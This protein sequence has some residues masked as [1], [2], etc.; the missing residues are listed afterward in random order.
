MLPGALVMLVMGPAS[1]MIGERYGSRIPLGLGALLAAGGLLLLGLAHGTQ[2]EVLVFTT[3]LFSGIGLAF[4]AMPNLIVDAVTPLE[5]GEATGFNALVRSIGSSLGSQVSAS[6]LAGSIVVA[7]GAPSN[8]SFR[9]AFFVG[10]G[11][12]VLAALMAMLI[13]RVSPGEHASHLGALESA[14][15]AGPL[16]EPALG[17][18]GGR[19]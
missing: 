5:T 7:G 15:A 8:A 6:I 12:A 14:G 9:T 13:P 1:G 3:V 19:A 10:A 17:S 11:V 18:A 4:A 16:G 2:A